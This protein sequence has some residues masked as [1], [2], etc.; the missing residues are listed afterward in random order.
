MFREKFRQSTDAIEISAIPLKK[1][2]QFQNP[3]YRFD[4]HAATFQ[5]R[6]R[7][8]FELIVDVLRIVGCDRRARSR[9]AMQRKVDSW[10]G[11]SDHESAA[12]IIRRER[13]RRNEGSRFVAPQNSV[14]DVVEG[15]PVPTNG[16]ASTSKYP[17][18]IEQ[19]PP[20]LEF[21]QGMQYQ[22][23]I[24]IYPIN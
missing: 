4:D 18:M 24:N 3:G 12:R 11:I 19:I 10:V 2:A 9:A 6:P 22:R 1:A 17:S 13:F 20:D 14:L 16:I 7:R 15:Q 21:D 8:R 23:V 5:E